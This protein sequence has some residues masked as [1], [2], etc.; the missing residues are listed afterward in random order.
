MNMMNHFPSSSNADRRIHALWNHALGAALAASSLLVLPACSI[1][2]LCCPEPAAPLPD[3][4]NG[5]VSADSSAQ[6]GWD[7]FFDDPALVSLIYESLNGNQELK[8]LSQD[9]MIANNEVQARI[10][11]YLPFFNV[12]LGADIEKPGRYTRDGA[13]EDQLEIAPGKRFPEPLPNFLVATDITWE[14]DIW[15]KLRNARD[16]AALRY[17][18]TRDG[19]NF[20]VTRLVAEVAESY[21]ELLALDNQMQTLDMTIGIQEKSLEFSKARKEAARDTELA[22]QRFQAEVQKNQSEKLIILQRSIEVEN[23]INFLLGRFPQSVQR[24]MVDF[25]NIQLR[26]LSVGM[27]S[28]L[29]QNRA[30]I[31]QA[32]REMEA[33]GLDVRVARARFFPSLALRAGVGWEAFDTRYLFDTPESLAYRVGGDLVAPIINRKAIKADYRSANS[34]QLQA[35]YEY[36]RTILNA[37]TEVVN[38]LNKVENYGKSIEVKKQQLASLE[39]SVDSATKLF[40]NARAEYMEVL[41]AQRDLME[42]RMVLIETKQQQLAAVVRTYQALGGGGWMPDGLMMTDGSICNIPPVQPTPLRQPFDLEPGDE[43]TLPPPK[44][45]AATPGSL[46]A[47]AKTSGEPELLMPISSA[48]GNVGDNQL[49]RLPPTFVACKPSR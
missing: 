19:R 11:D 39:A 14:I 8:I 26:S 49:R 38:G 17:L 4:F 28:Q 16:A 20:V 3:N 32:E 22:V 1:P 41:L 44:D 6:L 42:A 34:R 27:P 47:P 48:M 7:E 21:Y 15:R 2:K 12:G 37:F 30:D 31:R 24:P 13:V 36:Q 46:P 10:G 43:L 40:Q 23:R 25:F 45:G 29:L 9:I 33:A 18:G 35:V 5:K